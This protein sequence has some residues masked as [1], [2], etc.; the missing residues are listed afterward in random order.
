MVGYWRCNAL[1]EETWVGDGLSCGLPAGDG[2]FSFLA[3]LTAPGN[4]LC[5]GGCHRQ[6]L[7]STG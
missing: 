3:S 6:N 7:I 4:T 5:G 2:T 1:M